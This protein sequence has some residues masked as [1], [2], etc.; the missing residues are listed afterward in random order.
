MSICINPQ[1]ALHTGVSINTVQ[2]AQQANLMLGAKTPETQYPCQSEEQNIHI[3]FRGIIHFPC[4]P[5]AYSV[6]L[7]LSPVPTAQVFVV[8]CGQFRRS[9]YR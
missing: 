1:H 5:L 7:L 2:V 6:V 9:Q 3:R 4:H 8:D